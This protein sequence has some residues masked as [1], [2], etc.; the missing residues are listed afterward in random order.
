MK[1][2]IHPDY[3]EITVSCACGNSFQTHATLAH[4]LSLEIC[5]NCHPFYTGNQRIVDTAGRVDRFQQRYGK[6]DAEKDKDADK[7]TVN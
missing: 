7:G 4:D 3:R 5:N 2:E 1:S 6:K